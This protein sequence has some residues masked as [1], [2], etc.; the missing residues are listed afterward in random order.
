MKKGR[1]KK[2]AIV[3]FEAKIDKNKNGCWIFKQTEPKD[4]YGIFWVTEINSYVRAHRFSFEIYKN[5]KIP[6]GKQALHKCDNPPC[7]NPEH[8]W[9]GSH[10][11][12]MADKAMKFRVKSKLNKEKVLEARRMR[13]LGM[14]YKK[15]AEELG[16]KESTVYHAINK[17][18]WRHV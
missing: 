10:K 8:L 6:K 3:R 16:S 17:T 5:L 13:K 9:L 15:I 14:T 11:E 12:N 7:V 1:K 2:P 4:G 18:Y